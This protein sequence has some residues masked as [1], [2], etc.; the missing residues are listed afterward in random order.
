MFK[1]QLP[2]FRG[3][4]LFPDVMRPPTAVRMNI[5]TSEPVADADRAR[6]A[7]VAMQ[8]VDGSRGA[9]VSQY[10]AARQ[11]ADLSGLT[12][13]KVAPRPFPGGDMR[14]SLNF[15]QE[16]LT[17]N[18]YPQI[19]PDHVTEQTKPPFLI[20]LN[21]YG[22]QW[23][24]ID[25]DPYFF[26]R[27]YDAPEDVYEVRVNQGAWRSLSWGVLAADEKKLYG[28]LVRSQHA[29]LVPGARVTI[30][31]RPILTTPEPGPPSNVLLVELLPGRYQNYQYVY[32]YGQ[33]WAFLSTPAR[34]DPVTGETPEEKMATFLASEYQKWET[35]GRP[36]YP[37]AVLVQYGPEYAMGATEEVYRCTLN[38]VLPV[39]AGLSLDMVQFPAGLPAPIYPVGSSEEQWGLRQTT[40]VTPDPPWSNSK[41]TGYQSRDF[42]FTNSQPVG[43]RYGESRPPTYGP[44]G[45]PPG[46]EE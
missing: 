21:N 20:R 25:F 38:F 34:V 23:V 40:P 9:L 46:V 1:F 41:F 45:P 7:E 31:A 27:R 36:L 19:A 39:N 42:A 22:S 15:G 24:R 8:I 37:T 43:S 3:T 5:V 11:Q 35:L 33:L 18:V 12:Y 10:R 2:I 13:T 30:Q 32:K 4:E 17:L 44:A 14:L 29:E 28:Y 26:V 6:V 16:I